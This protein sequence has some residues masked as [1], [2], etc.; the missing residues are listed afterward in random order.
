V[1]APCPRPRAFRPL[2]AA[3]LAVVASLLVLPAAPASADTTILCRGFADCQAKGYGNAG[4]SGSYTQMWWR[5]YAG[6]NCTN[7]AAY[8]IVK[9]GMSTT[10]P[11]DGSGNASNWGVAL[12]GQTDQTP[13]VGAIAWWRDRGHVQVVERVVNKDWI[14][15]SEDHW[16]GDF[17]WA[18]VRRNSDG[19]NW[20]DGFIHLRDAGVV[21]LARPSVAG[22]PQVGVPLTADPGTW[23]PAG[24]TDVQWLRNG[25]AIVGATGLSFTPRPYDLGTRLAV[26]VVAHRYGYVDAIR[27]SVWTPAVVPGTMQVTQAPV[28]SGFPKVTGTLTVTGA[29]FDPE[30]S[31]TATQWFADGQ[32]I[33]GA[34]AATLSLGADLLG[35]RISVTTTATRAG[36]TTQTASAP[37]TEPVGPDRIRATALPRIT[38]TPV[39]G[40]T[41]RLDP[42]AVNVA[43]PG[44]R[45]QWQRNGVVFGNDSLYYSPTVT[46]LGK[47]ISATVTYSKPGYD[48]VTWTAT[49]RH[50]VQSRPGIRFGSPSSRRVYVRVVAEGVTPVRGSVTLTDGQHAR[51]LTLDPRG[52][53]FFSA[54]WITGGRHRYTAVYNG[55]WLV[56]AGQRSIWLDVRR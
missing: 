41:L 56:Q 1:R 21:N 10:R 36:Y 22:T 7:Y 42:G 29:T 37:A 13:M 11:W 49:T 43:T 45:V 26:R 40:E 52:Q 32:P 51:T 8:R 12:A 47:R 4:Y 18:V 14:V 23:T 31:G 44:V 19:S 35:K 34:T 6:H 53:A 38:G 28:V 46:D 17:D 50:A 33:T 3:L 48:P 20:P 9:A 30:P 25:R 27:T 5:M 54:W 39:L 55:S 15:V 2:V 16:G 24:R